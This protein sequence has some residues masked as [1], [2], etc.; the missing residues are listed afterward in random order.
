MNYQ[1]DKCD[2]TSKYVGNFNRHKCKLSK[3]LEYECPCEGCKYSSDRK[4]CLESH[5]KNCKFKIPVTNIMTSTDQSIT[6]A[7]TDNSVDNSVAIDNSTDNSINIDNSTNTINIQTVN[8]LLPWDNPLIGFALE[9][10]L[11]EYLDTVNVH[12]ISA[13]E[14]MNNVIKKIYFNPEHPENHS[15]KMDNKRRGE[16]TVYT[17]EEKFESK[18]ISDIKDKVTDVAI[19]KTEYYANEKKFPDRLINNMADTSIQQFTDVISESKQMVQET[20][21]IIKDQGPV[22]AQDYNKAFSQ[23]ADDNAVNR[24]IREKAMREQKLKELAKENQNFIKNSQNPSR[25]SDGHRQTTVVEDDSFQSL[26]VDFNLEIIES[27]K[28]IV[29]EKENR[30]RILGHE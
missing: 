24:D 13:K 4:F 9:Q 5:V 12:K 1:C 7:Q 6:L 18:K 10:S 8:I 16:V 2:Y 30:M 28:Q 14:I 25:I 3:H 27:K 21:T 19:G 11:Q 22:T 20:H 15:I 23:I 17:N 29:K 26:G